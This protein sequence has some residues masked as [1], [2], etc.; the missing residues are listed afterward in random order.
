M[1]CWPWQRRFLRG[2]FDQPDDAAL[3]MGRG[4][5]KTTFLAAVAAAAV[6]VGGPL[7]TPAAETLVVASSF[8]QGL[9]CYRH[10]LRFLAPTFEEHGK[11]FR[12][13]DS[14]SRASVLD[15]ESG[16]SVRVVGSD[17][18]RLHGAAP[19]LLIY[20]EMAQWPP[21][22][23]DAMLAAL[24]TS[25]GKIAD[26]KAI[27]IGTRPAQSGHPFSRALN[28]LT[29]YAQIHAA[30]RQDDPFTRT[31]WIKANPGLKFLPDLEDTIKREAAQAQRSPER[32]ATFLA[33]RL[34]QG[35]SDTVESWLL[36][37]ESWERI[38]SPEPPEH[39]GGYSLGIDLGTSAAMSAA[40]AYWPDT[41]ALECLAAFPELPS[42]AERGL[43]DGVGPLYE[44]CKMRGELILAGQRVSDVSALLGEALARWGPPSVIST[45]RWREQELRERLE[46][47]D[48]PMCDLIVRGQGYK[49]GGED[50]R[51]FRAAC[52][53]DAVRAAPSLLL[54]SAMAEARTVIDAAG[55]A[56]LAKGAEGARRMNAR[57]DAAA[58]AIL[59]VAVGYRLASAGKDDDGPSYVIL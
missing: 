27:W 58:A 24:E 43:R 18:R 34:N 56:K 52:L 32:L 49:D 4:G 41:G 26:S 38:Q 57:D 46:A 40:A 14:Q 50:V 54:T 1:T 23:I 19:R 37:P 17:P 10:I 2:A 12:I 22:Q 33:L 31:T 7:V 11:R 39:E 21:G 59:A 20:D 42:L 13:N 9:I 5:G 30:D 35:V 45:D 16:A 48:F 51:A 44:N 6:D 3:T 29:G 47:L 15:R 25:R 53:G 55:N 28:G 36:E 8:E